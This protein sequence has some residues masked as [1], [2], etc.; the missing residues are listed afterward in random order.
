MRHSKRL[1][2]LVA[3]SRKRSLTVQ[4]PVYAPCREG[5]PDGEA[6]KKEAATDFTHYRCSLPAGTKHGDVQALY[7][8]PSGVAAGS[9]A[10][11]GMRIDA[12]SPREGHPR[13]LFG[14]LDAR[15]RAVKDPSV[16]SS[17]Q[18]IPPT[19]LR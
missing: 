9:L 14:L 13:P 12:G 10:S 8:S 19:N 4:Y 16:I 11:S 7:V 15:V 5:H 2:A 18:S 17:T 1:G 6:G 3:A